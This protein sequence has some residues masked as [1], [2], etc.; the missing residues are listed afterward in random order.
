MNASSKLTKAELALASPVT[1]AILLAPIV[2]RPNTNA[3]HQR[4]LEDFS[5]LMDY[6]LGTDEGETIN[7]ALDWKRWELSD[8]YKNKYGWTEIM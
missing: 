4:A 6:A 1:R 5:E 2:V 3:G 7:N 8:F